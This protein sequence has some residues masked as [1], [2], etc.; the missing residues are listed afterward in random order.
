MWTVGMTLGGRYR[1]DALLGTD[2]VTGVWAA[3]HLPTGRRVA[4]R[5]LPAAPELGTV[6]SAHVVEEMR[7]VSAFD[8]VHVAPTYEVLQGL[9]D[10]PVI[11]SAL[12]AGETLAELLTKTP[13][14]SLQQTVAIV[15]PVV[16]AVGAAHARGIVHGR[17]SPSSI[18]ICHAGGPSKV[19]VL[20]FGVAKWMAALRPPPAS[21][22]G[23][24]SPPRRS[25]DY[26]PPEE[27]VPGRTLDHRA[28]IWAIGIIIYECLSGLRPLDFVPPEQAFLEE[29]GALVPI[30]R[31]VTGLPRALSDAIADLVVA[32]PEHR[33]QNLIEFFNVLGPLAEEP[34]PSFGWPGS[35]RRI[36]GLTQGVAAFIPP[37]PKAPAAT[38]RAPLRLPGWRV[39]ALAASAVAAAELVLLLAL[40]SRLRKSEARWAT[41]AQGIT[42]PSDAVA[43]PGEPRSESMTL[44]AAPPAVVVDDF[45]G[46]GD[47]PTLAA[48]EPWQAF[49]LHASERALPLLRGPGAAGEHGLEIRFLMDDAGASGRSGAG[50]ASRV[51]GGVLDL[52]RYGALGFAH[53]LAPLRAPGLT[54][55]SPATLVA[56]VS[57]RPGP[58][59][60]LQ[61]ELEVPISEAWSSASVKLGELRLPGGAAPSASERFACLSAVDGLGFRVDETVPESSACDGGTLG[62]DDVTLR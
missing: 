62:I 30:E 5:Q 61:L 46:T 27:S 60:A 11:A 10:A 19:L 35:E 16:S 9:A 3:T 28:D 50:A 57:C 12:L 24:L 4:L 14:L 23:P 49:T 41:L 55:Q 48:L 32:D 26:A 13:M 6:E 18:F 25:Y 47:A 34:S 45:E 44:R 15:L 38:P 29:A 59:A 58:D 8:H 21:V 2:P 40:V 43:G 56:F 37:E 17:L 1:L 22:R 51:R 7:Y 39:L 42:T 33:A 54:C 52:T 36:T 20:D 53:R 31:H